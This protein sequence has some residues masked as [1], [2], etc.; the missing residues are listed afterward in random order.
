MG[1][2]AYVCIRTCEKATEYVTE[3]DNCAECEKPGFVYDDETTT[4]RC[5]AP[6]DVGEGPEEY[7]HDEESPYT[8]DVPE[9]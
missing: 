6:V 4:K 7:P 5:A 2:G 9:D 3:D 8:Y 1:D